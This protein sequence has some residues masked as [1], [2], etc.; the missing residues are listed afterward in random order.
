MSSLA[1]MRWLEQ[2]P[3]RYDAGMRLLTLG[4]AERLQAALA[5]AATPRAEADVL[6]IGCG[7]GALTARLASRGARVRAFD[8]NPEMLERTRARLREADL[9][10]SVELV[11]RSAAEIDG[12]A[13]SAFDAVLASFALSEM[14]ANERAYVLRAARGLLRPEGRLLV[15]DE[16]RPRGPV[17]RWL[18][19]LLRAPQALLA[20]LL[21]GNMSRPIPDLAGEIEAAGFR[22][23]RESRCLGE[24][25]TLVVARA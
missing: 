5:E 24:S 17:W 20:W 12:L 19:A 4:R 22:V 21:A 2:A 6:E 7:T 23:E 9:A 18:H 25:L 14:S 10:G 8:S 15:A 11:E 16:V 3:A 1:L 13:C